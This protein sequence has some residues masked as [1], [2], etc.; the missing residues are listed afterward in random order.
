MHKE[1]LQILNILI[2]NK[3]IF[4]HL[5]PETNMQAQFEIY[6]IGN[7]FFSNKKDALDLSSSS[8]FGEIKQGRVIYSIL[9]VLYLLDQKRAILVEGKKQ[10]NFEKFLVQVTKKNKVLELDYEVFKDLRNKGMIVKEGLKFGADFRV[11]GKGQAP[12]KN[13]A[14]Y[15]IHVTQ[16][17]D[18][19]S[20]KDLAAKARVAH[21]TSKTLL[22]AIIDSENDVNYYDINWKNIR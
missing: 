12:G 13:H 6:R 10:L 9:E 11:Y 5:S 20:M 1:F 14:P 18:K 17:K 21:S 2:T 4:K 8:F 3:H 15:L 19:M 22:L 7:T 16:S